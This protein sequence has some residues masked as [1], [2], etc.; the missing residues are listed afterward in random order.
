MFNSIDEFKAAL[1]RG[2]N[3]FYVGKHADITPRPVGIQSHH[4]INSVWM[5]AKYSN[6]SVNKAPSVYM[7]NNPNHNAT[8]GV[9]NTWAKE[10]RIKQG[11]SKVDYTKVTKD[12]IL[13]LAKKQFDAADTPQLV[14]DEYYKLWDD[15]LQTLTPK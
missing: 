14:R 8:R 6:Y 11:L 3:V 2:E 13:G 1:A 10:M 4:G 9:F 15:Y 7:L 5:K 12:D